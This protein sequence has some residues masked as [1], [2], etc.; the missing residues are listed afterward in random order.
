MS[1]EEGLGKL[2]ANEV[3]ADEIADEAEFVVDEEYEFNDETSENEEIDEVPVYKEDSSSP[4]DEDVE[5]C[6]C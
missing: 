4:E 5:L 2:E 1:S 3:A 6:R